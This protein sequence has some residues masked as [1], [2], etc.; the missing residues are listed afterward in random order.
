[1]YHSTSRGAFIGLLVIYICSSI[2]LFTTVRYF[3][4][5]RYLS[6]ASLGSADRH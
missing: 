6:L 5:R 2:G 1:L 4:F 3:P